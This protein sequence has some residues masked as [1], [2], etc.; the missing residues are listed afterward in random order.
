MRSVH[1][2]THVMYH[3]PVR[4]SREGT[5]GLLVMRIKYLWQENSTIN[6]GCVRLSFAKPRRCTDAVFRV[7][8]STQYVYSILHS[9]DT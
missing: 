6:G 4:Y 8:N 2:D 7:Q 5:V 3:L 1:M 9:S